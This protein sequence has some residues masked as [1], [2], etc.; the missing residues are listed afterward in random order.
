MRAYNQWA[1][2]ELIAFQHWPWVAFAAAQYRFERAEKER[3]K[4]DELTPSE[5]E[6]L[7]RS[8]A[9]DAKALS[10]SLI[11]LHVLS[12]RIG[13]REAPERRAHLAWLDQFI[14]QNIIARSAQVVGHPAAHLAAHS[15]KVD[16]L[17]RLARLKSA[18]E[19]SRKRVNRDLL[20]RPRMQGDRGLGN[21][22]WRAALI[23]KSLTGRKASVNLVTRSTKKVTRGESRWPD[24]ALFVRNIAKVAC[25]H[26]PTLKEITT[27]FRTPN[28]ARKKS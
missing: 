2:D 17:E 11:Q 5:I 4:T 22:T 25:N 23:W 10:R 6:K 9:K 21:L 13:D 20:Q 28:R 14:A 8:I 27:A 7:L 12:V 16:L 1:P 19:D 26:G 18:A 15:A 3:Y 24:F